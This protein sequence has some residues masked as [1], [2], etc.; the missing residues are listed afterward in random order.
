[1][2]RNRIEIEL[3]TTFT[4]HFT[5]ICSVH[6]NYSLAHWAIRITDPCGKNTSSSDWLGLFLDGV[7]V[8]WMK[9]KARTI[10][11]EWMIL[12]EA[13]SLF[14]IHTPLGVHLKSYLETLK[15]WESDTKKD[16]FLEDSNTLPPMESTWKLSLPSLIHVY[17][18]SEKK[19]SYIGA[20]FLRIDSI[21]LV[22]SPCL[23]VV[24][25]LSH[26]YSQFRTQKK[27]KLAFCCFKIKH[28]CFQSV[29][30]P[31]FQ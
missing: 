21:V 25:F 5:I 19:S 20:W 29:T 30:G 24:I 4:F 23:F 3:I 17:P 18:R 8:F 2:N 13:Y 28:L 22:D 15:E 7:C 26:I 1:M 9:Y 11:L 10:Y 14:W 6:S 27:S 31:L 16:L 12:Q